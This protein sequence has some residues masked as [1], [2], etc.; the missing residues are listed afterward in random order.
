MPV[1]RG[2]FAADGGKVSSIGCGFSDYR[3]LLTGG[4]IVAMGD[5]FENRYF[6]DFGEQFRRYGKGGVWPL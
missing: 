6:E 4:D 1:F 2:R 5:F 3:N